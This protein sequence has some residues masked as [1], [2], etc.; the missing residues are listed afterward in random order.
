MALEIEH[1]Y[2]V[3]N[4][5]FKRLADSSVSILQGYLSRDPERTVRVRVKGERGY[6]TV[7]GRNAGATRLEFE[8]EIGREEAERLLALC[9]PPILEKTRYIVPYD[10]HVWEVDEFHGD[11]EG[12]VTAEI[13]LCRE[14]EEY[15]IPGFIGDDVTDN[16]AYYNSN[17]A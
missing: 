9:V 4:D 12:L 15:R 17:L 13:E 6:L 11:R 16:P 10:G 8:Y 3:K 5:S 2:L 14:D 7:K 1:K